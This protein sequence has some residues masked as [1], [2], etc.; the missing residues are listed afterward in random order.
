MP[1][2][3]FKCK[4]CDKTFT[5]RCAAV[6]RGGAVLG[7][8]K[9]RSLIHGQRMLTENVFGQR[10]VLLGDVPDLEME[11]RVLTPYPLFQRGIIRLRS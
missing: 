9:T 4:K 8:T 2:K 5:R 10:N 6:R 1:M 3:T 7:R 11:R